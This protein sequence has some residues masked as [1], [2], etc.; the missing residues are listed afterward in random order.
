MNQSDPRRA[1]REFAT[2]NLQ[3]ASLVSLSACNSGVGKIANG[4]EFMGFKRALFMA[5]AKSALVS[6]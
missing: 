1:A 3:S 2:L 6:P 4:E 5:I